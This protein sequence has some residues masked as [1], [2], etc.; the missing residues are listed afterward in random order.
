[1]G[2]PLAPAAAAMPIDGGDGVSESSATVLGMQAGDWATWISSAAAVVAAV[3]S[4]A[5]WRQSRPGVRWV[6]DF[7][8]H[9]R[10]AVRNTGSAM[11]KDVHIRVGSASDATDVE[12][13]AHCATVAPGEVVRVLVAATYGSSEDFAVTVT[14]RGRTGRRE[15]WSYAPH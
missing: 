9:G 4:V 2:L 15:R 14:W 10:S 13:E 8:E 3:A 7:A 5:V 1:M 6:L 12:A 11:A